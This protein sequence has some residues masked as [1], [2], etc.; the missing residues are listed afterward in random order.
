M[1]DALFQEAR[2]LQAAR[3]FG[4]A[5][6]LYRRALAEDP[7]LLGGRG[8]DFLVIG[9]ARSGTTWLKKSLGY[10]PEVRMLKGEP[11]YFSLWPKRS[12]LDYVALFNPGNFK[13]VQTV[14]PGRSLVY[15]DKSP[16]YLVMED[17]R[18]DLCAALFPK[19]KII[20]MLREPVDRA[21]SQ[22]AHFAAVK[23]T[24][25]WPAPDELFRSCVAPGRYRKHLT[26]WR[27][28]FPAEQ[29]HL[30]DYGQIAADPW[31]VLQGVFGHIGVDRIKPPPSLQRVVNAV[32][33]EVPPA[34]AAERLRAAYG[35]EPYDFDALKRAIGL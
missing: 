26:R 10:H 15:G 33:K 24:Q 30:I 14:R 12:P 7:D 2:T 11:H 5:A 31:A 19:V 13:G 27:R 28:A 21:W 8:P 9:A 29:F 17:A 1:S 3:R 22:L 23:Q 20:C 35:E 16:T 4:E 34:S 32:P 18:I 25:V 6:E